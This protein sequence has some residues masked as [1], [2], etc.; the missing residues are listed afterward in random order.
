MLVFLLGI[1]N[2]RDILL[3]FVG[4]TDD[5]NSE[6]AC[7][8]VLLKLSYKLLHSDLKRNNTGKNIISY[9]TNL[10]FNHAYEVLTLV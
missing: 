8:N 10:A 4:F 2:I 9:I 1:V 7:T 6:C 5:R 3:Q